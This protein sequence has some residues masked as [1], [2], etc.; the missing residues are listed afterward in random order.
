MEW[1]GRRAVLLV[2][3]QKIWYSV[4]VKRSSR[5]LLCLVL[6]ICHSHRKIWENSERHH[7][8]SQICIRQERQGGGTLFSNIKCSSKTWTCSSDVCTV[9]K[10]LICSLCTHIRRCTRM[11][12]SAGCLVCFLMCVCRLHVICMRVVWGSPSGEDVCD[13][14]LRS[15]VSGFVADHWCFGEIKLLFSKAK[16]L[17]IKNWHHRPKSS[18]TQEENYSHNAKASRS[19]KAALITRSSF[20]R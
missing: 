16:F 3:S 5:L 17:D 7:S 20:E 18:V 9:P 4:D 6:Y 10:R 11:C 12:V 15:D 14:R 2:W 1:V 13:G 19:G 8:T